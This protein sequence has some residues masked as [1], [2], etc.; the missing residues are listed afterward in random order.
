VDQ[1]RL[2]VSSI[3]HWF[4]TDFGGKDKAVIDHLKSYAKPSLKQMLEKVVEIDDHEY[5]WTLNQAD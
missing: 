1:G 2:V 4:K 3:Y 5:D